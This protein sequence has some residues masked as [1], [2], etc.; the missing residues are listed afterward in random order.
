MVDFVGYNFYIVFGV[1]LDICD[2][3]DLIF[4]FEKNDLKKF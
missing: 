2:I 3:I 1:F 4:L